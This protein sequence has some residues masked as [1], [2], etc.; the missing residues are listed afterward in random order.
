MT[1]LEKDE[2]KALQI[3]VAVLK[4][5]MASIQAVQEK[6]LKHVENTDATINQAKGAKWGIVFL[7]TALP[8]ASIFAIVKTYLGSGG[9]TGTH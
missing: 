5:D 1:G 3:E 7:L 4:R 8:I 2:I 9:P 6:I